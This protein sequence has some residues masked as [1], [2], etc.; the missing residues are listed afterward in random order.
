[1]PGE[2]PP[3]A[4]HRGLPGSPRRAACLLLFG[5][6]APSKPGVCLISAF[7]GRQ[8]KHAHW[9]IRS[10]VSEI[11]GI[12]LPA[13]I[14][15]LEV[16]SSNLFQAHN[17]YTSE[18]TQT[19]SLQKG[20]PLSVSPS[21]SGRS[22][23]RGPLERPRRYSNRFNGQLKKS[24]STSSPSVPSHSCSGSK[25]GSAQVTPRVTTCM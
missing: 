17:K 18:R 19:C 20:P 1:M 13:V 25:K 22:C 2:D 3:A 21:R 12:P 14:S 4:K 10:D 6:N 5:D 24:C 9:S 23:V 15:E 7:L 16:S 8:H 11:S